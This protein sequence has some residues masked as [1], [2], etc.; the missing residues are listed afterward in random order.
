MR[1]KSN[2]L[3]SEKQFLQDVEAVNKSYAFLFNDI[4][5]YY[6]LNRAYPAPFP[7]DD[8]SNFELGYDTITEL[9]IKHGI[10]R[11][12]PFVT[13]N[14]I[15]FQFG[16]IKTILPD[17]CTTKQI[18]QDIV[19]VSSVYGLEEYS[20]LNFNRTY[21]QYPEIGYGEF[22]MRNNLN[23]MGGSDSVN[24][25]ALLS[26]WHTLY[27][28]KDKNG[29]QKILEN[30]VV[31]CN[32]YRIPHQLNPEKMTRDIL[33]QDLVKT[34]LV[35]TGFYDYHDLVHGVAN[36]TSSTVNK[37]YETQDKYVERENRD[38]NYSVDLEQ[39]ANMARNRT[40]LQFRMGWRH[41]QANEM[42]A[43]LFVSMAMAMALLL[44][45]YVQTRVILLGVIIA[46]II[47]SLFGVL[48]YLADKHIH[49]NQQGHKDTML[50]F[51]SMAVVVAIFSMSLI[52]IYSGKIK[53]RIAELGFVSAVFSSIFLP[54]LLLIGIMLLSSY[55]QKDP[56]S[57]YMS[58]LHRFEP[59]PWQFAVGALLSVQLI[60]MLLRRLQGK[61][62]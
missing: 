14:D 12:K 56:C 50:W 13:I 51:L 7:L 9:P 60:F 30:L 20:L 52:S 48:F 44:F 47:G 27:R 21:V 15:P 26:T 24:R 2:R 58:T 4:N 59:Q 33:L 32:R 53:K 62:E 39:F 45:K 1:A 8:I 46:G 49:D 22:T 6:I 61:M 37:N 5:D 54:M 42:W 29:I 3:L 55:Q 18:I 31:V 36:S 23:N 11:T 19:D 34:Q 38:D 41:L 17:S 28:N 40:Q 25:Q 16:H 35:R 43:F 57:D 10:D